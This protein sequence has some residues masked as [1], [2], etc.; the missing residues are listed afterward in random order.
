TSITL[1]PSLISLWSLL[2]A[3]SPHLLDNADQ[4]FRLGMFGMKAAVVYH[5]VDALFPEETPLGRKV[6]RGEVSE[7]CPVR[8]EDAVQVQ[9]LVLSCIPVGRT[10]A[11][12]KLVKDKGICVHRPFWTQAGHKTQRLGCLLR[13]VCVQHP[14]WTQK[15]LPRNH[16]GV[17]PMLPAATL[18]KTS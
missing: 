7:G 3:F 4:R 10:D 13:P 16:F 2:E 6:V 14:L 9:H 5:D 18:G 12:R 8:V 17:V 15:L 1:A 11:C